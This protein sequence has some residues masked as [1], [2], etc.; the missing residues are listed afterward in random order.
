[1]TASIIMVVI[2]RWLICNYTRHENYGQ[3]E[4]WLHSFVTLALYGD[5]QSASLSEIFIPVNNWIGVWVDPRAGLEF[6]LGGTCYLL[7][8][9]GV[10]V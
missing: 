1:M 4:A 3:V 9:E 5:E 2:T 6:F 8:R 10:E 7:P